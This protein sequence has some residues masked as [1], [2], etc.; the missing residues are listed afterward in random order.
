MAVPHPLPHPAAGHPASEAAPPFAAVVALYAPAQ[1]LPAR[2]AELSEQVGPYAVPL[3][4]GSFAAVLATEDPRAFWRY[5]RSLPFPVRI[6]PAGEAPWRRAREEALAWIAAAAPEAVL[7]L[8]AEGAPIPRDLLFSLLAG[9][10]P[11]AAGCLRREGR[12]RHLALRPAL[13]PV[14][15]PDSGGAQAA[16]VLAKH[17]LRLGGAAHV[18]QAPPPPKR[19]GWLA[20]WRARR[21]DDAA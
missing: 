5:G 7:V 17:G 1:A 10:A 3:A 9:L 4:R 15:L 2:L 19:P 12:H 14:A 11:D 21:L 20:R 13:L 18:P 8:P 6:L 16:A